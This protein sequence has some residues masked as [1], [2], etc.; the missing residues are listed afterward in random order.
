MVEE[1]KFFH[2][3][4]EMG[5]TTCKVGMFDQTLKNR[6]EHKIFPTSDKDAQETLNLM[7][8]FILE[9][10]GSSL[11]S[12]GIACF[13][14]LN[15][16]HTSKD[17]GTITTTPKLAWQNVGI[18]NFFKTKFNLDNSNIFIDTD[19]N[20]CAMYEFLQLKSNTSEKSVKESMCYVTVG[21]G[22][23]IGLIINSKTVHG[24]LHPE[25]GH[26]RVPRHPLEK[27][28]FKGVCPF[29]G[30]CIEGM[31]SNI[32]IKER[33]GLESVD[34]VAEISDEH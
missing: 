19:C 8:A 21:T 12:I 2:V 23:G 29:H 27:E 30:D 10:C 32:S 26:V 1:S 22:V 14:P 6:L 20:V 25:G 3:G 5:G 16:D 31:T 28:N 7:S 18:Y 15:L 34:Q 24:A 33:L 17:F 9:K 13:G 11:K 4:I